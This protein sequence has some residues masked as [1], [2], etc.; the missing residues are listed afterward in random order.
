M[1]TAT[2]N[3]KKPAAKKSSASTP[4]APTVIKPV[5]ETFTKSALA[6]HLAT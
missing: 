4:K 2:K 1:A 5:K 6:A 3:T